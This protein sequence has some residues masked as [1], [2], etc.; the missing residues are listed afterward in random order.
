M[1]REEHECAGMPLGLGALVAN[2]VLEAGMGDARPGKN[3]ASQLEAE[4]FWCVDAVW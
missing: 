1:S 3:E 4:G 2:E